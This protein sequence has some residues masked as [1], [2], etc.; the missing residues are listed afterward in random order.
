[1]YGITMQWQWLPKITNMQFSPPSH[2]WWLMISSWNFGSGFP[3]IYPNI[4]HTVGKNAEMNLSWNSKK[5][6]RTLPGTGAQ[7]E[8]EN[9]CSTVWLH[10]ERVRNPSTLSE[11][12]QTWVHLKTKKKNQT[13]AVILEVWF[14]L[15]TEGLPLLLHL[16]IYD[17]PP[18]R[19]LSFP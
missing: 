9:I 14:Q 6:S 12:L 5:W 15:I 2:S 7:E 11:R 8:L 1:M 4:F 18:H 13:C 19:N 10:L 16:L 3:F 17:L